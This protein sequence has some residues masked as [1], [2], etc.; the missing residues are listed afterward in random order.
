MSSATR[1]TL[2]ASALFVLA[3]VGCGPAPTVSAI[4]GDPAAW[5]RKGV[6]FEGEV[7][8]TLTAVGTTIYRFSDGTDDIW[9]LTRR[10]AP[11]M[12][13]R[14]SLSARVNERLS[15]GPVDVGVHLVETKRK[16]VE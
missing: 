4:T 6:T 9:V 1:L 13:Q 14:I 10:S 12:G 3:L 15:V 16:P 5:H 7:G 2:V 8:P 11:A